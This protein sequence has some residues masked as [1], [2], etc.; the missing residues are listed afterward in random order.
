[1]RSILLLLPLLVPCVLPA[2]TLLRQLA[3]EV[4]DCLSDANIVYPRI[5]VDKCMQDVANAHPQRIR[6]ELRLIVTSSGDRRRLGE[7]LIDPL[8][9][10]CSVV[11]ELTSRESE[12][13]L[14]YSDIDLLRRSARPRAKKGPSADRE[15]D[16]VL[17]RTNLRT[18][19]GELLEI[20]RNSLRVRL[21][22]GDTLTLTY[23]SRQL[24][25]ADPR[26]GDRIE[27]TYY[28]DWTADRLRV[29]P[30]LSELEPGDR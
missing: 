22:S 5:Q 16:R 6:E 28:L 11:G 12:P 13:E 19:A 15:Q 30:T 2:Q 25:R 17:H 27:F 24:R 1:M 14:H 20:G 21:E 23:Q 4:C 26:A 8:A 18:G 10:H 9:E 29:T 3:D 7:L